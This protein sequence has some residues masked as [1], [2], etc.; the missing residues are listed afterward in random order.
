MRILRSSSSLRAAI[1]RI[2][3]CKIGQSWDSIE[4][5]TSVLQLAPTDTSRELK[6]CNASPSCNLQEM[7][8][9]GMPPLRKLLVIVKRISILAIL[10]AL[11][12]DVYA[13]DFWSD[14]GSVG[15]PLLN[16]NGY[17]VGMIKS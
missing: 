11:T 13:V 3:S 12:T 10:A 5:K 9:A 1:I 14:I 7:L 6:H 4:K 15:A 16:H 2:Y 8:G 17:V